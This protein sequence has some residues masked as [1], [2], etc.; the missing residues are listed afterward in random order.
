MPIARMLCGTALLLV[1]AAS[2]FGQ[3]TAAIVSQP[4]ADVRSGPSSEPLYYVTNRLR[5]GDRVEV[6]EKKGEWLAIKAPPG[7]VSW[8]NKRFLRPLPHNVWSVESEA[9]VEL[10]Y[11]SEVHAGKPNVRSLYL[12]RGTQLEVARRGGALCPCSRSHHCGRSEC[13]LHADTTRPRRVRPCC[14]GQLCGAFC[15]TACRRAYCVR[16]LRLGRGSAFG[17]RR[18]HQGSH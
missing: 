14:V 1:A 13:C 12:K 7:S 15:A 5:Q 16:E 18:P 17:A 9:D 10:L 4:T 3:T 2:V 8:V 6:V 11:G